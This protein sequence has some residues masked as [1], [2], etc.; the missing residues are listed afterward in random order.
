MYYEARRVLG[1]SANADLGDIRRAYRQLVKQ[2][3]PDVGGDPDHFKQ[4]NAA[5]LRLISHRDAPLFGPSVAYEHSVR[6]VYGSRKPSYSPGYL[7][8]RKVLGPKI[9]WRR[10]RV[11]FSLPLLVAIVLPVAAWSFHPAATVICSAGFL[12]SGQVKYSKF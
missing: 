12:A 3:H 8:M 9:I 7:L 4:I 1:V 2:H 11:S 5:Y 6:V 10:G